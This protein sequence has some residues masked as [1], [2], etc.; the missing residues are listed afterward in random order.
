MVVQCKQPGSKRNEMQELVVALLLL[1][2]VDLGKRLKAFL[3]HEFCLVIEH[4]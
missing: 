1:S 2:E 3:L 4:F